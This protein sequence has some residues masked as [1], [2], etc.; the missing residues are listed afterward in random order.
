MVSFMPVDPACKSTRRFLQ[1]SLRMLILLI[2]LCAIGVGFLAKRAR[3]QRLVVQR[4]R[5]LGGHVTYDYKW[6]ANGNYSRD[7]RPPGWAWLRNP[8]GDEYF[9]E[10][11]EVHCDKTKITDD[12]L[13][14]LARLP[15]LRVLALNQ[16]GISDE[17]LTHVSQLMTLTYLGL[18]G[19]K[20]TDAGLQCVAKLPALTDLL[21]EGTAIGDEGMTH[22]AGLQ[23]DTVTLGG[24]RI[25]S[26]GLARLSSKKLTLL[27]VR[28]TRVDD[29]SIEQLVAIPK[30]GLL[31]VSG[32]VISGPG[33]LEMHERLP[34]PKGSGHIHSDSFN[35]GGRL[36]DDARWQAL[37]IRMRA[38]H[39][40]GRIKL[41]DL[42][43]TG[44]TDDMAV[45]LHELDRVE[46]IDLRDTQV[47]NNGVE[48]LQEAL[49]G[50]KIYR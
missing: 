24:T 29:Q 8:I 34:F 19:T 21:L 16:T 9:Q 23:L 50:C 7:A 3:D 44:L 42:S 43:G 49:P 20:I 33:L 48:Q 4:V 13:R 38:V 36:A 46:C 37:V 45:V 25:T 10:V 40:E 39:A 11:V 26:A 6:D 35:L 12:D 32:T 15:K 27:S 30:L 41:I 1:I 47:T 5:E 14:L 31:D 2:T 22:L 17:G 28:D 18:N